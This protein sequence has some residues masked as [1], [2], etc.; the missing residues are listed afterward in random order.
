MQFFKFGDLQLIFGYVSLANRGEKIMKKMI[1]FLF[2][3]FIAFITIKVDALTNNGK[4]YEQYYQEAKVNVFASDES[5]HTLDYNGILVKSSS[6]DEVY[7]CIEPE[8][9]M[10]LYSEASYNSHTI[11]EGKSTIIDQCRLTNK[12]YD[13]V[14]LLSYYGYGYKDNKV[15]HNSKKWYGITQVLI[16]GSVRPDVDYVFKTDR[17]G[18]IDEKLYKKEIEELENLI[19][20]HNKVPSFANNSVSLKSGETIELKDTTGVLN[21][22]IPSSSDVV[23]LEIKDNTLFITGLKDGKAEIT[24]KK[25]KASYNFRLYKSSTVQNVVTRG[26]V[27][28]PSFK[29]DI[30]IKSGVV[31]ISKIDSDTN[32]YNNNLNSSVFGIYDHDNNLIKKVEITKEK[33]EI[34]LN[35]G[36]YYLKE[37]ASAPGYNLNKNIYE[38]TISDEQKEINLVIPNSKIKGE[39]I[40]EK[41]KGGADESFVLEEGAIFEIYDSLNNLIAK[42]STD[43][44]GICKTVLNYGTYLVKQVSG[45]DGYSY[46]D[47]FYVNINENKEYKYELKNIKKSVLEIKKVDYSN[48]NPLKDTYF[49]IYDLNDNLVFEGKTNSYGTLKVENLDIGKYYIKEIIPSKYYRLNPEKIEFEVKKDGELIKLTITNER[50][51]GTLKFLKIDSKTK[52]KLEFAKIR[53]TY[54]D[55]NEVL[56]EGLT[57]ENGMITLENINAGNYEIVELESPNGYIKNKKPIHF[58]FEKENEVVEITME[59]EPIEMPNTTETEDN[60]K[61]LFLVLLILIISRLINVKNHEK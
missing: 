33:E 59:N 6:D 60:Y 32:S 26:N 54:L 25:P 53:I 50:N 34:F 18:S 22:F 17:Y 9:P 24:F 57:D 15:N 13:R 36:N 35:Y 3:I 47:S 45:S 48:N 38:F 23:K 19:K 21:S 52:E 10:P 41:Y 55:T 56:F 31:T 43:N 42:L 30:E 12:N 51:T 7:Y 20:N 58:S 14:S 8:V 39:L 1:Y 5:Y 46:I 61:L 37:E 4:I 16:W 2:A 29:L 40:L 49:G 11:Y 28:N 44:N 27:S